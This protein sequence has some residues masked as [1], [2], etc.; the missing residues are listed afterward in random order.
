[1]KTRI[2]VA[3]SAE[4]LNVA[5][6]V[7]ENLEHTAE[8][9]VWDQGI[10]QPSSQ[11]YA[12]LKDAL[13][14]F[15]YAVFVF[16]PNDVTKIRDR[17]YSTVRDNV[18]FELGLFAGRFGIERCFILVPR[19]IPD[20]HLPTDLLGITPATFEPNR[21]DDN[22]LAA[23]GPACNRIRRKVRQIGSR[24]ERL[25]RAVA[26][27]ATKQRT[28]E[29]TRQAAEVIK[30]L[31]P[32][33]PAASDPPTVAL[34][35]Y[36]SRW[37]DIR[38]QEVRRILQTFS[39]EEYL[40]SDELREA[41]KTLLAFFEE[42]AVAVRDGL[43]DELSAK[44][45]FKCAILLAWPDLAAVNPSGPLDEQLDRCPALHELWVRWSGRS[46]PETSTRK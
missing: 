42:L 35:Q 34:L 36:I 31:G 24:S 13:E 6:L 23:L 45:Y 28:E 1:M 25:A 14:Q 33:L 37:N 12:A 44:A 43:V 10:F 39:F 29:V 11:T 30:V 7:Q 5:Y 17:E 19:G 26:T 18:V 22:L 38:M 9:T 4:S 16:T 2:I 27:S 32:R 8:V 3:S 21:D 40:E 20:F 46:G 15:D 41:G